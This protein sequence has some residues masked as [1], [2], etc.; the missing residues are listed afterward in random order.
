MLDMVRSMISQ[1][2]HLL[3]LWSYALETATFTLNQV[4]SKSVEKTPYEIWTGKSPKLSFLEIWGCEAYVKRL[5]S[6]KL[7]PKSDKCYFVGY[8]R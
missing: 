7:H 3:S 1:T 8:P 4:P 2:N 5:T 6:D